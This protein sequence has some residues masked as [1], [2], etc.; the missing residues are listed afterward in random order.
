MSE[1]FL[2]E[3]ISENRSSLKYFCQINC[4]KL[5]EKIGFFIYKVIIIY[6]YL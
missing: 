4:G 6:I 3:H 5:K 2:I 1:I